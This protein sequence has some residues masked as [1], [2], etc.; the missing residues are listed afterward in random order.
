MTGPV[1][2]EYPPA[3]LAPRGLQMHSSGEGQVHEMLALQARQRLQL[4]PVRM[5]QLHYS[6]ELG[7]GHGHDNWYGQSNGSDHIVPSR[8]NGHQYAQS[9]SNMIDQ[10]PIQRHNSTQ[11]QGGGG[12]GGAGGDIDDGGRRTAGGS[13][14]RFPNLELFYDPRDGEH[15]SPI[16]YVYF[17]R[18]HYVD[19]FFRFCSMQ[20]HE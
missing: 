18:H 17:S 19:V 20:F 16:C 6:N 10:L 3:V 8:R 1:R 4:S 7:H 15:E 5:D 11:P 9:P 14:S 2:N 13:P 12:G